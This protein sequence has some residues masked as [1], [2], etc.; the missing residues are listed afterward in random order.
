[1][2]QLQPLAEI[3]RGSS[4]PSIN[5]QT[6]LHR[7]PYPP[8]AKAVWFLPRTRDRPP[9]GAIVLG[10]IL[11]S[12]WDPEEPLNDEPPP[13][14]PHENIRRHEEPSWSWARELEKEAGGGVFAS[15]LQFLGA[16]GEIDG[17]L[18]RR[19]TEIYDAD[20]LTTEIFVPD[21]RYLERSVQDDGVRDA[22]VNASR[23]SKVFMVTGLK[24]AYGA[25]RALQTLEKCGMH[26]Q[27]GGDITALSVPLTVGPIGHWSSSVREAL[28]AGKSDFVFGFKLMQ[29]KYKKGSL[30]SKSYDRG[31]QFGLDEALDSGSEEEDVD[32]GAFELAAVE[33][34]SSKNFGM[35]GV[36]VA[37]SEN[38]GDEVVYFRPI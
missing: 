29:L 22:L 3:Y 17:T 20:R 35:D 27:V 15:F 11:K 5:L 38:G 12:P 28:S 18:G 6:I 33:D 8:S 10:A 24:I 19:H 34:T 13:P 37:S 16:G 32:F 36:S 21:K 30:A 25:T 7:M 14:I 26:V 31:A 2:L 9:K 23:G 4:S 1:M